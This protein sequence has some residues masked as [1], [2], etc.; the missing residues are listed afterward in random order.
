M[1]IRDNLLGV[2]SVE[3]TMETGIIIGVAVVKIVLVVHRI[4][5]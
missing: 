4:A 1:G 3:I 5:W 2:G